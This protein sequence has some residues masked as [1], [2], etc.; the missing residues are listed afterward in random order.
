MVQS[1]PLAPQRRHED[2]Q[3][4]SLQHQKEVEAGDGP[5]LRLE[6]TVGGRQER[7]EGNAQRVV[8]AEGVEDPG[9]RLGRGQVAVAQALE[10]ARAQQAETRHQ[11]RAWQHAPFGEVGIVPEREREDEADKAGDERG[12][13]Q[14]ASARGIA[15]TLPGRAEHQREEEPAEGERGRTAQLVRVA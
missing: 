8:G 15:R 1:D 6:R 9:Q 7:R 12:N 2:G 13:R 11:E 10:L 14:R 4:K 5:G 3:T